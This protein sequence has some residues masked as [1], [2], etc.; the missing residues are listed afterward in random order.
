MRYLFALVAI[1]CLAV[2]VCLAQNSNTLAYYSFDDGAPDGRVTADVGGEDSDGFVTGAP[3]SAC[4]VSGGSLLF[5]GVT[6]YVTFAGT[7]NN[8]FENSNFAVSLYFHPTGVNPRQTLLRKTADC[9]NEG[10]RFTI[11]YLAGSNELE[12]TY[13]QNNSALL[14]GP[15]NR[16]P[17]DDLRCWHH[18]VVSYDDRDLSVY[19]NGERRRIFSSSSRFNISNDFNLEFARSACP[20]TT[21]NFQGFIDEL[22]IFRGRF[23]D[24]DLD[25]LYL[26]P[27]RIEPLAFPVINIGTSVDLNVALTCA[28]DFVWTPDAEIVAGN[29]TPTATVMPSESTTYFVRMSYPQSGC[30][31]TDSVLV[32]VFDP[33]QFDCTQ[34]LVPSAFTPDGTGPQSNEALGISNAVTLQTFETFQVY[35]RWGNRVFETQDP[36]GRW[37]GTY[38]GEPV[39]PGIYL[40]RVAFGCNG[41]DIDA[42][43]SVTVLK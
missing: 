28:D 37:D 38:E 16:I 34:V 17:L 21:S 10:P 31:S 12:I 25:L 15:T 3:Q 29:G 8:L 40:W 26:A 6:D 23:D 20:I 39:Q 41:E 13:A 19:L 5:D 43:G 33:E 18:L 4:G 1:C 22:Y 24:D 14:G 27:D 7:V 30:R 42:T 11:D 36:M 35:D 9:D 2:S 32:Q